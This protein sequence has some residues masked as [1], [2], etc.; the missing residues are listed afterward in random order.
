MGV[1]VSKKLQEPYSTLQLLHMQRRIA[2]LKDLES[3]VKTATW[4]LEDPS[5]VLNSLC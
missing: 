1:Y 2:A 4:N 3:G 5:I